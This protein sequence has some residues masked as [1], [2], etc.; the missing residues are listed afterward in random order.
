MSTVSSAVD[1]AVEHRVR[2]PEATS[3]TLAL[4]L[5]NL[6]HWMR[7]PQLLLLST[8]Q[9]VIVVVVFTAVFRGTVG[10]GLDPVA[11]LLPGVLVQVVAFDS[12]QTAVGLAEDLSDSTVDRLRTM[13]VPRCAV[14]VARTL[15][16]ACRNTAVI[17]LMLGAGVLVGFR[18]SGG[19]VHTVAALLLVLAFAYS[20]S[21][22]FAAIG[23]SVRGGAEAANAAGVVWIFPMVFASTALAPAADLPDWMRGFA[24]HQ[25]VSAV[26]DGV[27]ALL[28]GTP[29]GAAVLTASMWTAGVLLVFVPLSVHRFRR[30]S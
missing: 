25:P 19:V 13:P 12:L 15:A 5:R 17:V 21:W 26:V 28:G 8:A 10:S 27:R 30:L 2:L 1:H 22:V 29:A 4:T 24:T 20:L 11:F 3:A 6:L 23:L 16:D 7:Q 14:L 9:P 18:F